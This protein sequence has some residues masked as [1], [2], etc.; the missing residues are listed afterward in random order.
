MSKFRRIGILGGSF[1]PI[2]LGH[3]AIAEQARESLRLDKVVFIPANIPPHKQIKGF[4]SAQ[5]RYYLTQLAC[6]GNPDFQVCDLEIIRGGVSY[7]VET[8]KELKSIY[9]KAR[10]YFI[11]GADFLTEFSAWK[12]I[13]KLKSLCTFVVAPRPGHP[14]KRLPKG[15]QAIDVAALEISSTVIR[16][17]LKKGKSIRYLVPEK[18]QQY[19]LRK[20]LYR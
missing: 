5:E 8:L 1:N 15:M 18:V 2:H 12:A 3:L 7:S 13:G 14:L 20:R 17:R 4:A 10:L 19:I 11:A 16:N 6:Q 9:P